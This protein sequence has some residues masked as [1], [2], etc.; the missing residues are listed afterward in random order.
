MD[1]KLTKA[2]LEGLASFRLTE[3][4]YKSA[5]SFSIKDLLIENRRMEIIA[6]AADLM[7]APNKM[8]AASILTKRLAFV[9][10]IALYAFFSWDKRLNISVDNIYVETQNTEAV[11]LP[12]F[13]LIETGCE[14]VDHRET[15]REMLCTSIFAD[16][17]DPIMSSLNEETRLSKY[18]MWEN[19]SVY[20]F[21]L[22]EK[23]R[24]EESSVEG[25]QKL[26]DDFEYVT[27]NAAGDVFGA[28]RDNPIKRYRLFKN[29]NENDHSDIRYRTTCCFS[30]MLT[31]SAGKRCKTCPQL[32]TL[33]KEEQTPLNVKG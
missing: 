26:K 4:A 29:T 1:N 30:Y 14:L 17:M 20:I 3:K 22:F 12:E 11:W 16:L 8:V 28:Y 18:I 19:V 15:E 7:Q 21:W 31:G 23:L 5:L 27:A 2:E 24:Q 6:A 25:L 33:P 9:P 13:R 32:C 10:A